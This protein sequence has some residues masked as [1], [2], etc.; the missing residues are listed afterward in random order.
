MKPMFFFSYMAFLVFP[1][2]SHAQ[3]SKEQIIS[4]F[5]ELQGRTPDETTLSN[6][7]PL[8]K[9]NDVIPVYMQQRI[10]R[11]RNN[12]GELSFSGLSTSVDLRYRDTPILSQVGSRCSAYGLIASIENLLGEPKVAKL[13]ESHL[14]SSY[15]RYSSVSAVEAAKRM[16]IT[17]GQMWPHDINSPRPGWKERTHTS[18]QHIT[19]I[20]DDVVD[21]VAALNDKRPVYIGLSVS[22]AMANCEVVL[23][24]NSRDT[25]G[26]HAISMSGYTLDKRVPGGGYFIVKNSWGA[27]C[28]D[29]GY[30]YL[31]FSYCMR[32]GSSYCIMW[33][34]QGVKTAFPGVP[35]IEPEIPEF[36]LKKIKVGISS[37]KK[38]YKTSRNVVLEV[39][40]QSLHVRQIDEI[41]FSVDNGPFGRPVKNNLDSV[42]LS[43]S[44]KSSEHNIALRIKLKN[45]KLIETSRQWRL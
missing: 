32:G 29:S 5:I 43:F 36:D 35:S 24:P 21:A 44:T 25:G 40:G 37:F 18:L 7:F 41:S 34:V 17:E 16:V 19:F 14:W 23:D 31:P 22:R 15:R 20:E 39:E 6:K 9:L 3:Y 12:E 30:Q 38:W 26:G 28:G 2:I 1:I 13:S 4:K 10:R 27:D 45:G 8:P 42:S 33:D 11:S